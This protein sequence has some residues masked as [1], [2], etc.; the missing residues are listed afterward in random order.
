MRIR[1]IIALT[2]LVASQSG[3]EKHT[4][5]ISQSYVDSLVDRAFYIFNSVSD[6]SSGIPAER[7]V[8]YGKQIAA[9]LREIARDDVNKKY[10]L[11]RTGELEAQIYLEESGLLMEKEQFRA[12][13]S[14]ELVMLYN[15]EIGKG[16]PDFM[17]LWGM[18]GRMKTTDAAQAGVMEKSIVK[19][20][21]ALSREIPSA[22]ELSLENGEYESAR[23]DLAY[24]E[25]NRQYLSLSSVK[26]ASM[27]AKLLSDFSLSKERLLTEKRFRQSLFLPGF[28]PPGR[29]K[30]T[31]PEDQKQTGWN[32]E[33]DASAGMGKV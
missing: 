28:K 13:E 8:E 11:W 12:K 14:N 17:K 10:I 15:G 9:K 26:L 22:V 7:A 1:S 24:C 20:A 2:L 27:Q 18:H 33:S 21:S 31:G 4:T 16:R 25:A 3:A 32:S 30:I 19:R 23:G 5:F 6:P 29:I